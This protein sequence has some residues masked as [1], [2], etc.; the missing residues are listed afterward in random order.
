MMY[1][2]TACTHCGACEKACP[3]GA[4]TYGE[5]L[6]TIIDRD[7][8]VVCG[9]CAEGCAAKALSI[10]GDVKTVDEIMK[11]VI[12]DEV[13]YDDGGGVTCSGG[14]ILAQP[15]FVTEIFKRCKERGIHTNADTSGFGKEEDFNNILEYSDL[16]FFDVKVLDA[17]KHQEVI[18]VPI[19]P[20]LANMKV[21]A[22]S[23]VET[24][25]RFP[26]VPGYND[27]DKNLD[28]LVRIVTELGTKDRWTVNILPYHKYGESKYA[29]V[30]K[31]YPIPDVPANTPDNLER[32]QK[33]LE[34]AGLRV[35]VS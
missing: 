27:D 13:Y 31:V 3:N 9:K 22:E 28:E 19:E 8:C 34:D 20:V 17:D 2:Y 15:E 1:R 32:V 21:L 10:S 16:C 7:K 29:A 6:A 23:G 14:E 18:G 26:L 5:G 30:G 11:T 35:I 33:K 25:L 4:I 24:V 12:R